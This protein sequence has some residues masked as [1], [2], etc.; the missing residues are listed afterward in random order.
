MDY[1]EAELR[2]WLQLS[3]HLRTLQELPESIRPGSLTYLQQKILEQ[4]DRIAFPEQPKDF[5]SR[6]E[7][8]QDMQDRGVASVTVPCTVGENGELQPELERLEEANAYAAWLRKK[9]E[10][11]WAKASGQ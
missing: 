11:A 2:P 5:R 7:M 8:F 3:G 10:A 9:S 1:L 6:D 4:M